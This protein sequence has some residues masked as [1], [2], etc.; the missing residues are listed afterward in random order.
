MADDPHEALR[1][2]LRDSAAVL[3]RVIPEHADEPFPG[4]GAGQRAQRPR[5]GVIE[6]GGVRIPIP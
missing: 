5:R 3:A 4:G 6:D 2:G 1:E